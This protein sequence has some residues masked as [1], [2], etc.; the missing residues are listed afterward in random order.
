MM[1]IEVVT[2]FSSPECAEQVLKMY[3]RLHEFQV[4]NCDILLLTKGSTNG[5]GMIIELWEKNRDRLK[6]EPR[7]STRTH[8]ERKFW[9][10]SSL[11]P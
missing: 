3:E 7:P 11:P 1:F 6:L 9:F 2:S 4:L 10:L 5:V 8:S